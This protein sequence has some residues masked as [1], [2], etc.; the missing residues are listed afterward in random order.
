MAPISC[1]HPPPHAQCAIG[2]Y[3]KML[4]RIVKSIKPE[5]LIRSAKAP[6]IK[7][8]VITANIHWKTTKMISGM[9]P[10]VS[11]DGVTPFS[12]TLSKPPITLPAA[13]PQ[14]EVPNTKL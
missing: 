6:S 12:I 1:S 4:H 11:A 14:R 9:L 7:A 13:V 3:T 8:G 2:L 5:N 10:V